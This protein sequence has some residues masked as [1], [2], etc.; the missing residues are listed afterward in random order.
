MS[1]EIIMVGICTLAVIALA[2][3]M[4]HPKKE[5]GALIAVCAFGV[6][7]L[8]AYLK[9][10]DQRKRMPSRLIVR[11]KEN[12]TYEAEKEDNKKDEE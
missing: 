7:V 8:V 2:W 10:R 12:K 5:L 9:S 6:M 11:D 4:D 1:R 3:L